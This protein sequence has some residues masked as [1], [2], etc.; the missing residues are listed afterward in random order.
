MGFFLVIIII[1]SLRGINISCGCFGNKFEV[2]TIY[3]SVIRDLIILF[4]L[5]FIFFQNNR[6]NRIK[7]SGV[8]LSH[9]KEGK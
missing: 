7:T 8:F 6:S 5:F 1:T 2:N 4:G 9:Q 3:K